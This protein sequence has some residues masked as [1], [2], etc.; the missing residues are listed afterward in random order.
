SF[1]AMP[2]GH[3]ESEIYDILKERRGQLTYFTID[4]FGATVNQGANLEILRQTGL[5]EV[6]AAIDD[7]LHRLKLA[8]PDLILTSAFGLVDLSH[9]WYSWKKHYSNAVDNDLRSTMI[10]HSDIER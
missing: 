8:S 4:H 3:V 2:Y 10:P 1:A 5:F 7:A 9:I 6:R